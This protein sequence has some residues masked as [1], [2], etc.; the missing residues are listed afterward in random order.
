MLTDNEC[1][2]EYEIKHQEEKREGS[3]FVSHKSIDLVRKG[4]SFLLALIR[5]VGLSQ[6]S[7]HKCIFGIYQS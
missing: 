2:V 1:A 4:C 5:L 6:C 7:L 3:P